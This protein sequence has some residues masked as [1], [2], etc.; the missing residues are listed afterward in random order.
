[1][2]RL[3]EPESTRESLEGAIAASQSALEIYEK[4]EVTHAA[5]AARA[6]LEAAKARLQELQGLGEHQLDQRF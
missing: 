2:L 1:L 4:A 6:N 5:N 3:P